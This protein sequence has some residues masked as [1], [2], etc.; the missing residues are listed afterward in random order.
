MKTGWLVVAV[1]LLV[2]CRSEQEKYLEQME[3]E[4]TRLSISEPLPD[5]ER[6]SGYDAFLTR[7]PESGPHGNSHAA[8]ARRRRDEARARLDVLTK[9]RTQ[10]LPLVADTLFKLASQA[11]DYGHDPHLIRMEHQGVHLV[12]R[13]ILH[14]ATWMLKYDVPSV[15]R[16]REVMGPALY[17]TK[18]RAYDSKLLS[19][20][21]EAAY[22]APGTSLLGTTT[23]QLFPVFR[24]HLRVEMRLYRCAT[25]RLA[26]RIADFERA[27]TTAR[28]SKATRKWL[29]ELPEDDPKWELDHVWDRAWW[30]DPSDRRSFYAWVYYEGKFTHDCG[31]APGEVTPLDVGFWIRRVEDGTAPGIGAALKRVMEAYDGEWLESLELRPI[32]ERVIY[33]D[34]QPKEYLGIRRMTDPARFVVV[35]REPPGEPVPGEEFEQEEGEVKTVAEDNVSWHEEPTPPPPPEF[36]DEKTGDRLFRLGEWAREYIFLEDGKRLLAIYDKRMD[37]V[38][39]E[40]LRV[41]RSDSFSARVYPGSVDGVVLTPDRRTFLVR[42]EDGH[43]PAGV[44]LGNARTGESSEWLTRL[45]LDDLV[46]NADASLLVG[47]VSRGKWEA[48]FRSQDGS[49]EVKVVSLPID[50][51]RAALHPSLPLLVAAN[52]SKLEVWDVSTGEKVGMA[53]GERIT[54]EAF[55]AEGRRLFTVSDQYVDGNDVFEGILSR[56]DPETKTFTVERRFKGATGGHWLPG[57]RLLLHE[58]FKDFRVVDAKTFQT[59]G[60][61]VRA[62]S[63]AAASPDGR[64]LLLRTEDDLLLWA[65]PAPPPPEEA[66]VDAGVPAEPDAGAA[67]D[68]GDAADSGASMDAGDAEGMGAPADA[69]DTAGMGASSDAGDVAGMGASSDAGNAAGV[70]AWVDGGNMADA[71]AGTEGAAGAADAGP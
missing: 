50:P 38:D 61:P 28:K 5:A 40:T 62:S 10:L 43:R 48:R 17:D 24:H 42:F 44:M 8:E 29:E 64:W 37:Q 6:M 56:L 23:D 58:G 22:L 11:R 52:N 69:G 39:L 2:G 45:T 63:F 1:L 27:F 35:Y 49:P 70:D 53:E 46:V 66:Q 13:G 54:E 26:P 20:L 36:R 7:F 67:A 71:G 3:A 41:E 9:R 65:L 51:D 33:I 31:I 30:D 4:W 18:R 12:R 47:E 19:E 16:L 32:S 15:T 34:D 55:D 25:E 60:R 59:V 14:I 21:L 68:A 57:G